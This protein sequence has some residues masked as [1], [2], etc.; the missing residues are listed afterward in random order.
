MS[1]RPGGQRLDD[2]LRSDME[3]RLGA[4]LS[5][6]RVHTDASAIER[7]E[8]RGARAFAQDGA[9]HFAA[10]AFNPQTA[11][12]HELLTHELTHAIQQ[13]GD[14][15]ASPATSVGELEAEAA[16]NARAGG[17][18]VRGRA[19]GGVTLLFPDPRQP[20]LTTSTL[21]EM[22]VAILDDLIHDAP[23]LTIVRR[24]ALRL[25]I[26]PVAAGDRTLRERAQRLLDVL[27]ASS[28]TI[29][30]LTSLAN[31]GNYLP[32]AGHLI[33][34]EVRRVQSMYAAAAVRAFG[35]PDPGPQ[36]LQR[37]EDAM[38][39]LPGF[40]TD[41]YLG[42]SGIAA[43]VKQFARIR[44]NVLQLRAQSGRP[45]NARR[46]D[47]QLDPGGPLLPA[48]NEQHRFDLAIETANTYRRTRDPHTFDQIQ[49]V[50]TDAQIELSLWIALVN[51][52]QFFL[53]EQKLS[54]SWLS[55]DKTQLAANW[56]DAF[57]QSVTQFE[58][59][60]D[61]RYPSQEAL[62]AASTAATER[63]RQLLVS[64]NYGSALDEIQGRLH[65]IQVVHAIAMTALITAAAA[66]T[67]GAAAAAVSPALVA[68]GASAE[69][70]ATGA[71]IAEGLA[72]TV[73]SRAGQQAV[74]GQAP[75][76]FSTDLAWNLLTLGAVKGVTAVFSP[77][78]QAARGVPR[79]VLNV[80]RAAT[81]GIVLQGIGEL[82]AVASTGHAMSAEERY[83]STLQNV[84]M[85]AGFE[86]GSFLMRPIEARLNAAIA[87]AFR[88]MFGSELSA[89]ATE[90]GTLQTELNALQRATATPA[91][92][93][94]SLARIERI[95]NREM[96][97]LDEAER[98]G[99]MTGPDVEALRTQYRG[100][101]LRLQLR[102]AALGI[103]TPNSSGAQ[104][105]YQSGGRGMVAY[106]PEGRA[107]IDALYQ[108][109]GAS[110]REVNR[111]GVLEG[112]LPS[113]EVT[114]YYP[115]SAAPASLA[116]FS[117]QVA[118]HDEA[119]A[120][121]ALDAEV[122]R[123]RDRLTDANQGFSQR[124][125]AEIL[126]EAP[127]GRVADFLRVLGDASFRPL[128][129]QA[130]YIFL[131]RHP[132]ALEIA[133]EWGPELVERLRGRVG[134]D[135]A[136]PLIER[137]AAA[138]EDAPTPADADQLRQRILG[139]RNAAQIE[140]A[141][142]A[143]RPPRAPRPSRRFTGPRTSDP[144]WPR[145]VAEAQQFAADHHETLSP[146]NLERRA[147][148]RQMLSDAS[149]GRFST[150]TREARIRIL[151]AY[152]E[153][154]RQSGAQTTWI[155]Q[156]RGDLAEWL[157]SPGRGAPRS[158]FLRGVNV[159]RSVSG[160]SILDYSLPTGQT[161]SGGGPQNEWVDLK[162]D[163]I[164]RDRNG[165]PSSVGVNRADRYLREAR[166]DMPNLPPGDLLSIH[167]VRD[168]GPITRRA[169][170]DILL[171]SPGSP[172]NRVKFGDVW[173]DRS[174]T[175]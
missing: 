11:V 77:A 109:Q 94:T 27:T 121:A 162:S 150:L 59:L 54:D 48:A 92:I 166:L 61:T 136:M 133:Q 6:L 49:R 51:Y 132:R 28:Q 78:I 73:V 62:T 104:P 124:K 26:S 117:R 172:V 39:A 65:T 24:E 145:F 134:D 141:L 75:G 12:G 14:S 31:P 119:A 122:A 47:E 13:A 34:A 100:Q 114:F 149:I 96:T 152:D 126:A 110:L 60:I 40:I 72:F 67:G 4:D 120:A 158:F 18:A 41:T 58:R 25:L 42:S 107:A 130:A 45:G 95:W 127:S 97:L 74:F 171:R 131:A 99:I 33:V 32:D 144:Q 36:M 37:A 64:P 140:V 70:A 56:R 88:G 125:A 128:R 123:G 168:P 102:L 157:F 170:L 139:A 146:A 46:A 29:K 76:S 165:Q 143:P 118:A 163:D 175:P 89:L 93:N 55:G 2:G 22:C 8:A 90:R 105:V 129:S 80:E 19:P 83:A 98:R 68:A 81:T 71:F 161:R 103:A 63:L 44:E 113:G 135:A 173:Y 112:R 159:G 106:A 69:V 79:F 154:G 156:G 10:G 17:G 138:L 108:G 3:R 30:S 86:L 142:G 66:L 155:N 111:T 82:H 85:L 7:A 115:T 43:V 20:Q 167:F 137:A 87:P 15:R 57:D 16:A 21:L 174:S 23:G 164:D 38:R 5:Q 169:M 84:M 160:V 151:D 9:V 91:Q 153:L 53:F 50:A 116:G 148:M 1:R 52:E 35:D 101:A 147:T